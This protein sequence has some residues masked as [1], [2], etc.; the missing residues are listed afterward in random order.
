MTLVKILHVNVSPGKLV[1][2][3][4]LLTATFKEMFTKIPPKDLVEEKSPINE[5]AEGEGYHR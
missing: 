2:Y 3:A 4:K 5:A 1:G